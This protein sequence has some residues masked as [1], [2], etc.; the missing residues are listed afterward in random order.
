MEVIDLVA[1]AA[2]LT[3]I[4]ASGAS[5]VV[6]LGMFGLLGILDEYTV[7]STAVRGKYVAGA[8]LI[9]GLAV[10]FIHSSA[11]KK[12]GARGSLLQAEQRG[13]TDGEQG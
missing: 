6:F 7:V 3:G 1:Q 12:K 8:I 5:W 11:S 10:M 2:Y 4:G 9:L 13:E